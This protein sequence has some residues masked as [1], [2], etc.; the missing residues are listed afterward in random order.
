MWR[1]REGA[2]GWLLGGLSSRMEFGG[3][4]LGW[5]EVGIQGFSRGR[6]NCEV[7]PSGDSRSAVGFTSGGGATWAFSALDS[8]S[9]GRT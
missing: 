2:W 8:G 4:G 7:H 5:V 6:G 9:R 1:L 3:Q